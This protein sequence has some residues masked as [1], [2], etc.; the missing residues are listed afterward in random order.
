MRYRT[1]RRTGLRVLTASMGATGS[2]IWG[3]SGAVAAG[4][5][6][7]ARARGDVRRH[8]ELVQPG[9]SEAVLGQVLPNVAVE[10]TAAELAR[11]EE[12]RA[13]WRRDGW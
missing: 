9:R 4:G 3:R 6:A 10:L 7:G 13:R 2:A 5:A 12:L 11:V 8:V 1:F